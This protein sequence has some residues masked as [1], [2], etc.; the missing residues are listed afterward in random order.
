MCKFFVLDNNHDDIKTV[1]N[2]INKKASVGV[3]QSTEQ[4]HTTTN[5]I[6]N[7]V[8]FQ[9]AQTVQQESP[10]LAPTSY[11]QHEFPYLTPKSHEQQEAYLSP[12]SSNQNPYLQ[13]NDYDSLCDDQP[14]NCIYED[15]D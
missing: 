14:P 1:S 11:E 8:Y 7:A 2:E 10:Y 6:K 3:Y 13:P 12:I 9:Q 15:C 4:A 5:A